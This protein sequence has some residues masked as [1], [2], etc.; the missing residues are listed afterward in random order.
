M[1]VEGNGVYDSS[2]GRNGELVQRTGAMPVNL[3][4]ENAR[5]RPIVSTRQPSQDAAL[6]VGPG[7]KLKGEI[8]SCGTLTVEGDV[9]AETNSHHL[10]VTSTGSFSGRAVV[11]EAEIDGRFEGILQVAGKLIIR[12]SARVSGQVNYGQ[13][14][15]ERGGEIHGRIAAQFGQQRKNFQPMK[16]ALRNVWRFAK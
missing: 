11:E 15:I 2:R 13:I 4:S 16:Y 5:P 6:H 10:V 8:S 1:S 7:V 14:E 12:R 9:E 3:V